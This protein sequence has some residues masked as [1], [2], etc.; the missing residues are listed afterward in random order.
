MWL[1]WAPFFL[2]RLNGLNS[3]VSL[4]MFREREMAGSNEINLNEC[5]GN[6]TWEHAK[7]KARMQTLQR[8]LRCPP[9]ASNFR[10]IQDKKCDEDD[11]ILT[12]QDKEGEWLIA[13][14]IPWHCW[15]QLDEANISITSV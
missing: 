7:L 6:W 4:T 9:M 14:D 11:Y 13:G 15:F 3:R 2:F 10:Y 12:Y 1:N 5:K 8:N